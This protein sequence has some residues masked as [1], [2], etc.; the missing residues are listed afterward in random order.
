MRMG[1]HE[2]LKGAFEAVRMEKA[3]RG[4]GSLGVKQFT[5]DPDED[6]ALVPVADAMLFEASVE[7]LDRVVWVLGESLLLSL[8]IALF[9]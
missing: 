4:H 7:F 3:E 9:A 5:V 1:A 8:P 6:P 2:F